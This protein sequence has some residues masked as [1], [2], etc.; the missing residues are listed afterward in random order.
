MAATS[1]YGGEFF[2]GEFFNEPS[3]QE[4]F[5]TGGKGDNERRKAR[6]GLRSVKPTG[7]IDRPLKAS[8]GV[9]ERID[10]SR[11]IQEAVQESVREAFSKELTEQ[12]EFKPISE[13]TLPQIDAEIGVLMRKKILN[14]EDEA[15]LLIL[16]AA[17][18]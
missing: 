12:F 17:A 11:E 4:A 14:D 10:V 15:M 13:M 8:P 1:F 5:K 3:D 16:I 2:G 6:K 9:E 18:S 7:L